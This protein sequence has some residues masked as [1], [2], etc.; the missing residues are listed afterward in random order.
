MKE[1]LKSAGKAGLFVAGATLVCRAV[2]SAADWGVEKVKNFNN[3]NKKQEEP[4]S[5]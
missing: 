5:K 1:T 3:K 4:A 2:L